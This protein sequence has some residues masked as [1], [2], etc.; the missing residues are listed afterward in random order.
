MPTG[1]ALGFRV[2]LDGWTGDRFVR[3][4]AWIGASR[5]RLDRP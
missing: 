3:W 4:P 1:V 5:D 2:T